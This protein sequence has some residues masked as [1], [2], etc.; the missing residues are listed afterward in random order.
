MSDV[1]AETRVSEL[2]FIEKP[3]YS[4]TYVISKRLFDIVASFFGIILLSP[5]L[6]ITAIA[7]RVESEGSAFFTQ[8]RNGIN[9]IP[10]K[11]FKFRSMCKDAPKMR[12]DMESLNELDGPAFKIKDD[13]RVTRIGAFIRKTSIDEL[14][15]LVNVLVGNMSLVGPRPLPTYETEKCNEYQ[16]QRMLVKP[17]ITCYWQISG[18][19]DMSF[20]EW[21]ELDLKYI[22]NASILTDLSILMNTFKAVVA[23]KGAY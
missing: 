13:P 18:R 4:R 2:H 21:V 10:F 3:Q 15:Q 12:P 1:V 20:D 5:L 19:N 9:G 8:E 23:R 17:G 11:M 6:L 14:P 16:R 22:Q 7:I